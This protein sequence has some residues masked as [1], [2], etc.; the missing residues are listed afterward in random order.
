[1]LIVER[2]GKDDRVR[3]E[4]LQVFSADPYNK[5]MRKMGKTHN[6]LGE[7]SDEYES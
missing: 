2:Q 4:M 7:I 1:M 6:S 3:E 5:I